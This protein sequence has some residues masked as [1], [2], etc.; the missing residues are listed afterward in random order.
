MRKLS[1]DGDLAILALNWVAMKM[2]LKSAGRQLMRGVTD[3]R[4]KAG[5]A[6]GRVFDL[7]PSVPHGFGTH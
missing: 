2:N 5:M 3:C 1:R 4:R 7:N 6:A